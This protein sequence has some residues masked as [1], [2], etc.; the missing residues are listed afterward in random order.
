MSD[1]DETGDNTGRPQIVHMQIDEADL[2]KLIELLSN[3]G[4]LAGMALAIARMEARQEEPESDV[5]A[6]ESSFAGACMKV[7]HHLMGVAG[8]EWEPYSITVPLLLSKNWIDRHEEYLAAWL[9]LVEARDANVAGLMVAAAIEAA[10]GVI[11]QLAGRA[12]DPV[13]PACLPYAP[14]M[15]R[16]HSVLGPAAIAALESAQV[17][18]AA[19]ERFDTALGELIFS[20]RH[21]QIVGEWA[22]F[23]TPYVDAD[24]LIGEPALTG[25]S[26]LMDAQAA[27][28]V[29]DAAATAGV[30]L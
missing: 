25:L 23:S 30:Q 6:I 21:M 24:G 11:E 15:E 14:M 3:P 7:A 26:N 29:K 16:F 12:P 2:P 10:T 22:E 27:A 28:L 18:D 13:L 8:L 5:D 20:D 1:Q 17:D 19:L 9:P 4:E